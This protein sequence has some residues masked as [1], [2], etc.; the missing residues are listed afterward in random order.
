LPAVVAVV[1]RAA[2]QKPPQA[3]ANQTSLQCFLEVRTMAPTRGQFP[4]GSRNTQ[5]GFFA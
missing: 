4:K 5:Q 2:V 3:S 1:V